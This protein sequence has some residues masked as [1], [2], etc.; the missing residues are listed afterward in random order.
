[1]QITTIIATAL[2]AAGEAAAGINCKGSGYCSQSGAWLTDIISMANYIDH[3]RWYQ[4]GEHIVCAANLCAF[5]Q[6]T[7][8]M[9]G[10]KISELLWDLKDHGCKQCGSIPV[11]YPSGDNDEKSHGI[12]TV[13][14]VTNPKCNW[15]A[16]PK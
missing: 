8:G 3:S 7:G 13:N 14:Y 11:F 12:L 9:P 6:N 5:L 4:N 10:T 1:M 15:G 2:L 16:C